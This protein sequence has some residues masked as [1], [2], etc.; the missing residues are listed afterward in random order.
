MLKS[1]L[2]LGLLCTFL[3]ADNFDN[4]LQKAIKNSPYLES[5]LLSI[6]QAQAQG[7]I[8]NRYQNPSLEV[9]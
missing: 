4:F 1:I 3:N 6:K 9:A 2:I 7:E 5:N 8:L